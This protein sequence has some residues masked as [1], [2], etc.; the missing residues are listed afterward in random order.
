QTTLAWSAG[1]DIGGSGST[2]IA[3]SGTMAVDTSAG[4]VYWEGTRSIT[5]NGTTNLTRTNSI[6]HFDCSNTAT[7]TNNGTLTI[8]SN[9]GLAWS[10]GSSPPT[11]VNSAGRTV[12]KTGGTGTTQIVWVVDNDGTLTTSAGTLSLSG[13]SGN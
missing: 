8:S 7:L 1:G 11:L 6:R 5:N 3:A 2:V 13:G 4:D 12:Q 10:C 9:A